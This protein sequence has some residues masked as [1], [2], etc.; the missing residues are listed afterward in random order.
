M[1]TEL[2][3]M[4]DML[5]CVGANVLMAETHCEVHQRAR[6]VGGEKKKKGR[7]IKLKK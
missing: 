1:K 6:F 4:M 3:L 5:K 2:W 7:K